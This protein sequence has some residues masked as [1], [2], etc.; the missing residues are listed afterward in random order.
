MS[1][2]TIYVTGHRNPDTDSIV[3]AMAYAYFKQQMGYDAVAVRIG[4]INQETEYVLNLFNEFAPP[5][6]TDIKTRI[7]DIDFDSAV[8][9]HPDDNLSSALKIMIANG[10]K[11][12]GVVDEKNVVVGMATLSDIINP[13]MYDKAKCASLI[14]KTSLE[15]IA[16]YLNA[17][18]VYAPQEIH[19]NGRLHILA[20]LNEIDCQDEIAL[21]TDETRFQRKAIEEGAAVIICAKTERVSDGIVELAEN[22]GC[23]VL[24]CDKGIYDLTGEI[25]LAVKVEDIMTTNLTFFY[26]DD[27]VDDVKITINKSRYR[28]YPVLDTRNH[29]IGTISRYHVFKS[30][31]RNLILVDHNE[32]AQSIE[33]AEDANI[34]EII[35]HHRVGGIKTSSPIFFR[36]ERVGCCAT[37]ITKIFLENN[38]EIPGDLAGL[39]C[40]AIISDTVN[41]KSVTCTDEDVNI[42][43]FLAEK[44]AL[45]LDVLGPNILKAGARLTNKSCSSIFHNDL[46]QF[47]IGK[48]KVSVSQTNV[49]NFEAILA[50]RDEM[51]RLIAGYVRDSGMNIVMMVF[52]LIDGSGSYVLVQGNEAKKLTET[53]NKNGVV[54]DG[55]VFLPGYISRKSQIIPLI[56]EALQ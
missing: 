55:F 34:L 7:R 33:G 36:N 56:T 13:T 15:D 10:K 12:I 26:Q 48:T 20:S 45:D 22:K 18:I 51:N 38:V 4:K 35:D 27:Y 16:A 5:L 52:S 29:L 49:V 6:A 21:T 42:A 23:A 50:I 43:N 53:L 41:F 40:C 11:V 47:V 32:L 2:N 30:A 37:I 3:S 1:R 19:S 14:A 28:S 24:T 46:K 44:A 54:V 17:E 8:T 31:N 9:C 25:Y 39:L